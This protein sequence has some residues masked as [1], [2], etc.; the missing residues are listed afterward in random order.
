MKHISIEDYEIVH[1]GQSWQYDSKPCQKHMLSFLEKNESVVT[2]LQPKV[3]KGGKHADGDVDMQATQE[4]EE[5]SIQ[6]QV[7]CIRVNDR[8]YSISLRMMKAI[9]RHVRLVKGFVNVDV[10]KDGRKR[11]RIPVAL[12]Q[13]KK[14]T[15]LRFNV[16]TLLLV[17]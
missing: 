2:W 6:K 7:P 12:Y 9:W 14:R 13:E 5:E 17:V 1:S 4:E 10:A 8:Y 3:D 15:Q 11:L 16:S